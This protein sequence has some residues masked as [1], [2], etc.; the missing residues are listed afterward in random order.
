M[1]RGLGLP[2]DRG[3]PAHWKRVLGMAT[4]TLRLALPVVVGVLPFKGD[5]VAGQDARRSQLFHVDARSAQG[6]TD[7]VGVRELGDGR[8][9]LVDRFERYVYLLGTDLAGIEVIGGHGEG[10]GEYLLPAAIFPLEGD[11]SAVWDE[12]Q[13][14]HV[15]ITPEGRA[16]DSWRETG[17]TGPVVARVVDSSGAYYRRSLRSTD[18]VSAI[19][20]WSRESR[21]W[22]GIAEIPLDPERLDGRRPVRASS[23]TALRP[24]PTWA[25]SEDGTVAVVHAD[26]YR[27]EIFAL[28]GTPVTGPVEEYERRPVTEVHKER[29]RARFGGLV[30]GI[31]GTIG[32]RGS[33]RVETI[34]WPTVEPDAWAEHLPPFEEGTVRFAPDGALWVP[35]V[36]D[37][38][39]PVAVDV[40]DR[41]GHRVRTLELPPDVQI[42]GFGAGSVY[43]VEKDETDLQFLLRIPTGG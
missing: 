22:Q 7:V 39:A 30:T 1:L 18:G 6:F 35:R 13:G 16:V 28:G 12:A 41:T 34:R 20:R 15:L 29:W 14:R 27:V 17:D 11:R 3:A 9:I 43:V 38:G 32:E 5:P 31:A 24:V 33:S 2:T 40:F 26:P 4:R 21:V 42:V 8:V 23:R 25:V 36:V 10:P 19:D 37:P